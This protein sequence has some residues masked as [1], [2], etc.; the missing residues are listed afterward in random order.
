MRGKFSFDPMSPPQGGEARALKFF[1]LRGLG[2]GRVVANF[3]S[4]KIIWGQGADGRTI[5]P[6]LE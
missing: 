6:I 1:F 2:G 3:Q 5:P 4:P